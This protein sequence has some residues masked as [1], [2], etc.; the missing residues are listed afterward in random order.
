MDACSVFTPAGQWRRAARGG[1]DALISL[2][3][4]DAMP[5]PSNADLPP[6]VR[7]HLPDHGQGIYRGAFNHAFAAHVGDPRQEEAAHRV[8]WAGVKCS[9]IKTEGG[10]VARAAHSVPL[11]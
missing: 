3:A 6:S 8:A 10:W 9:F 5:Y 7:Q 11:T 4:G 1:A 2:I